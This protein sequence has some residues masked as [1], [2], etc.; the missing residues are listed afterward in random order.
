VYPLLP[1]GW[2]GA[3]LTALVFL[4]IG[5]D[6]FGGLIGYTVPDN[7]IVKYLPIFA[8]LVFGFIFGGTSYVAPWRWLWCIL[9]ALNKK[10]YPDVNGIYVGTICSNYPLKIAMRESA[11]SGHRLEGAK[12]DAIPLQESAVAVELR[13]DFF[14]LRITVSSSP[15]G[16][17]SRAVIAKPWRDRGADTIHLSNVYL[18]TVNQPSASDEAMHFGAADLEVNPADRQTIS[19]IY[20]TKRRWQ[21]GL[22]TAG[23]IKL[24]WHREALEK[25]RTLLDYAI[26]EQKRID[27]VL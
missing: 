11:V 4:A 16:G 13:A 12:L 21:V 15:T 2:V 18:Q 5:I 14:R 10:L 26:E 22:N 20:W 24:K 6:N 25:G 19:G 17:T 9:P 1:W 27:S 8:I 23:V 7:L 3:A